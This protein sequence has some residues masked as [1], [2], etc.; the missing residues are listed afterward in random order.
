MLKP[1]SQ[2]GGTRSRIKFP[3]RFR[4]PL[5]T[6]HR[7]VIRTTLFRDNTVRVDRPRVRPTNRSKSSRPRVT[8]CV[9]V[10]WRRAVRFDVTQWTITIFH[11]KKKKIKLINEKLLFFLKVC[12]FFFLRIP[13]IVTASWIPVVMFARR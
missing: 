10:Q 7:Y 1:V 6:H 4:R 12:L 8:V 3:K 13:S 11:K 2:G 9:S 5:P